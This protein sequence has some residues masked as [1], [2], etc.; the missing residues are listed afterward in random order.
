MCM[1][2]QRDR[3]AQRAFVIAGAGL[4]GA[5]AAQ[6]L[7]EEGFD[8]RV[9]LLGSER[10]RPYERPPLSKDYLRGEAARDTVYVH[11]AGFYA[12]HDIELRTGTTVQALD[13]ETR[14]VVLADGERLRYER[15]LLATGAR[16]RRLDL[17]GAHLAGVHELRTLDDADALREQLHGATRVVVVG[18]GWIGC[19]VAASAR[20][21]GAEVDV[22]EPL[23][24]PLER[25]LGTE[26]GAVYDAIHAAHGVRIH[27]GRSV[28]RLEGNGR[29]RAVRTADGARFACDLVLIGVGV[30]PRA[31]IAQRAGLDVSNGIVVD[32][33]LQTSAPDVF[34]AGDVANAY[35]PLLDARIR[36]EHWANALNQ[37]PAAARNMLGA[38]VAY[39]RIPYFF[40]DQYDVGMEYSG[41]A[42]AGDE[43]VLRGDPSSGEFIAFWLRDGRVRAGMNV[44]V[45]DVSDALQELIRSGAPVD[46]VGLAD[47]AIALS[48]LLHAPAREG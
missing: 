34:A 26:V 4:A 17:P 19:E 9:V 13:T 33:Y 38:Q 35:H 31:E 48:D 45:W 24:T 2:I 20:Q 8:G 47:P 1:S 37:G 40:S 3:S 7:R 23:S 27:P 39:E 28:T 21:M 14:E 42:G 18:A 44:N 5:K 25:V 16:P 15:L 10:H 22:I 29:V 36:V 41:H 11:E 46:R 12:D 32:E 6:T 43:L 30:A